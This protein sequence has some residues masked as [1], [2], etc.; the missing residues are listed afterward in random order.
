MRG[1]LLETYIRSAV[2][3][4]LSTRARL[5]YACSTAGAEREACVRAFG[6]EAGACYLATMADASLRVRSSWG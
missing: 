5:M 2:R 3:L 4:K 1:A 6:G